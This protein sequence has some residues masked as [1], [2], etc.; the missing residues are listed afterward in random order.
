MLALTG[1]ESNLIGYDRRKMRFPLRALTLTQ[2]SSTN[3]PQLQVADLCAGLLNHFNRCWMTGEFD[4][5]ATATKELNRIE[6]VFDGVVPSTD[7]TPEALGTSEL[8]GSNAVEEMTEYLRR[9][10]GP[11][12]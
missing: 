1:E 4:E 7:V 8:G 11:V 3:N 12:G 6:W 9:R 10:Q 2:A 5:L